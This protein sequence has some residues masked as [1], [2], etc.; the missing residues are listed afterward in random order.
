M[1]KFQENLNQISYREEINPDKWKK[2][3]FVVMI[4]KNKKILK[5]YYFL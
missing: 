2:K 4:K 5:K 3:E 1:D